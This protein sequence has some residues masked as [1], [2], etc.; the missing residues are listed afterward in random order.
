M[1]LSV[2]TPEEFL[3]ITASELMVTENS[4]SLE[5]T[6]RDISTWSS[7]NALLFISRVNDE[8]NVLISST[9]LA[10]SKTLNDIYKIVVSRINGSI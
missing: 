5:T 6:F 9:D 8:T 4:I 3:A 10:S 1:N 2:M 7:L